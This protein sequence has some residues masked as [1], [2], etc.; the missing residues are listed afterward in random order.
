[1]RITL[2]RIQSDFDGFSKLIVLHHQ[3]QAC[4]EKQC[5]IDMSSVSWFD[6]NMCALLG[7]ALYEC[8]V[9]H[10]IHLVH[11]KQALHDLLQRNGFLPNFGFKADKIPDIKGT[12]IE[13]QRFDKTDSEAFKSYVGRHF[14]GKGIPNMSDEL[15]KRFRESIAELFDNA[16]EHSNT[17]KGIFA[18]GQ[19]FPNDRRL[20][21]S[22]VDLGSGMKNHINERKGLNLDPVEAI[23]WATTGK[24]TTRRRKDKRPGGL[25]LKLIKEFITLNRGKI[26]IVSDAGYWNYQYDGVNTKFF[27]L[28]F[29]G[30][31]VNIEINTADK[32][33]YCLESELGPE[34]IF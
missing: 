8:R 7:A 9:Q 14:V 28:P 31:V 24:N 22:I 21:F 10:R 34:D 1:M 23:I 11:M 16:I 15:H 19:Y 27:S 33:S 3:A 13:Y 32:G 12:T 26:Q 4:S 20:D 5:E 29:P 30:T 17:I 6:A 25:G 2:S 18:C